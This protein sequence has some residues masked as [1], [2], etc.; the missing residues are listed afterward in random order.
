[1]TLPQAAV[2]VVEAAA[3]SDTALQEQTH[4]HLAATAPTP[5]ASAQGDNV[6]KLNA[7][8]CAVLRWTYAA[9]FAWNKHV[10]T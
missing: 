2:A 10:F 8:I 6:T 7:L 3:L 5:F 1:V 4:R 9:P